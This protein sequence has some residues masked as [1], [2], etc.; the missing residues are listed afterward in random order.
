MHQVLKSK[1]HC[2]YYQNLR[3]DVVQLINEIV[4]LT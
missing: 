3:A 2:E 4:H 1:G